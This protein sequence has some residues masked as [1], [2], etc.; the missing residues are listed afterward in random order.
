[1]TRQISFTKASVRRAIAAARE[2]GLRVN[3][4]RQDGTVLAVAN[5]DN[6]AEVTYNGRVYFIECG[7]F[8]KIGFSEAVEQ[9][10]EALQA[11]TP[12]ELVLLMSIPGTPDTERELH[13]RFADHRHKR[14]WFRR[15]PELIAFIEQCKA[16]SK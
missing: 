6:S 15:T 4:I 5:D 3:E 7:D 16:A 10:L 2:A 12:Y 8:I 11:S 1:M 13:S 14:E 9:R